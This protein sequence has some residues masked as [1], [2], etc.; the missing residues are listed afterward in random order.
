MRSPHM[1]AGYF[2]D[3]EASAAALDSDG[4]FRTGDLGERDAD[5]SVRVVGRVRSAVKLAQGEFVA[6][7]RVESALASAALVDRVF[8]HVEPGAPAVSALR[9]ASFAP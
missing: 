6:C 9:S 1:I 2:G 4:Y 7:E 3:P 8:V 5:G